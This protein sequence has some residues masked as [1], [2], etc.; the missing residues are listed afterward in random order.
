[1][2]LPQLE[3]LYNPI[4][5]AITG[6]GGSAS[7]AELNKEVVKSLNLTEEELAETTS[8]GVLKIIHR[9]GWAKHGLRRV[10]ILTRSEAGVWVLTE[11]GKAA[12]TVNPKEINREYN[13]ITAA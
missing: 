12:G 4:L 7:S 2:A 13:R 5:Q 10:G 3:G 9:I 1:M 8:T 11:K 6:L